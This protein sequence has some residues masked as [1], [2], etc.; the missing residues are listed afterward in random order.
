[1]LSLVLVCVCVYVRACSGL[2][3]PVRTL[4]ASDPGRQLWDKQPPLVVL[5]APWRRLKGLS[6]ADMKSRCG[7]RPPSG[8]SFA[9]A[10]DRRMD[11]WMNR[12]TAAGGKSSQRGFFFF[13]LQLF[14]SAR[15][16][17]FGVCRWRPRGLEVKAD[18]CKLVGCCSPAVIPSDCCCLTVSVSRCPDSVP[19]PAEPAGD[20][21]DFSLCW[22]SMCVIVCACGSAREKVCTLMTLTENFHFFF[23][24]LLFFSQSG[25]KTEPGLS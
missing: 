14:R 22:E 3:E 15:L 19:Q 11:G 8:S 4:S 21:I 24:I 5:A 7:A 25:N 10:V 23:F 20:W 2:V 17:F 18:W 1:M 9:E 16:V 13:F 12:R 6:G